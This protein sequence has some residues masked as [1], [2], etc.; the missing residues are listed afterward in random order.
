MDL[1]SFSDIPVRI[2]DRWF[3]YLINLMTLVLIAVL[4]TI[5]LW[6]GLDEAVENVALMVIS[7]LLTKFGTAM[8][9]FHGSSKSN[10]NDVQTKG[11]EA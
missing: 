10:T 7:A 8:D 4:V 6:N 5:V 2:T 11:K 1:H 9:Y 3:M